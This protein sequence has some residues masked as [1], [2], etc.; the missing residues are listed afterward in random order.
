[1]IRRAAVL[2]IRRAAVLMIRRAAV[3]M[4]RRA[5]VLMIRRAA[6][7]I[8]NHL[9]IRMMAASQP[10]KSPRNQKTM[11]AME[12]ITKERGRAVQKGHNNH[13]SDVWYVDKR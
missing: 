2:M 8:T 10:Q 11:I 4:I 1:M 5:A 13:K 3:L 6:V 7:L 9:V 12:V